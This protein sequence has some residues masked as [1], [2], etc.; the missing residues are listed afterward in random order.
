MLK[1]EL[2]VVFAK[3]ENIIEPVYMV[4]RNIHVNLVMKKI[5]LHKIKLI[6][7][8]LDDTFW[9]GTLSEY[10][11]TII[12]NQKNIE[13]VENLVDYGIMNSICS[14]NDYE[15]VK[16]EFQTKNLGKTWEYFLFPSIN[17]ESKGAR[18]KDIILKMQ[19][20][21]ENVLFIDDNKINLEEAKHFCPN[22]IIAMP[23]IINEISK[24][25]LTLKT[26]DFEHKRLK[27]YKILENKTFYKKKKLYDTVPHSKKEDQ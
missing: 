1:S 14:K 3:S 12:L 4:C 11:S 16:K 22:L 13:L 24:Q 6:I 18:I 7:W 17:Y 23:D 21:E 8:D 20:R 9:N 26:H 2:Q 10:N 25:L 19:L 5:K 15:S 27:R